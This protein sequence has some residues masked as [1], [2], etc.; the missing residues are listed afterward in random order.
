MEVSEVVAVRT[1]PTG[2]M[3]PVEDELLDLVL[4]DPDLL[5]D[6][7]EAIIAASWPEA[8]AV[9]PPTRPA[10]PAAVPNPSGPGPHRTHPLPRSGS[11]DPRPGCPR[12][13]AAGRQRSPPGWSLRKRPLRSTATR[14]AGQRPRRATTLRGR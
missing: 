1:T 6:E 9:A 5:R 14:L 10:P 4:R 2:G 3:V 8:P 11:G 12:P 7:F 13:A